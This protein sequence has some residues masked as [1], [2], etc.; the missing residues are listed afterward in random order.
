MS[1]SSPKPRK[2]LDQ[3][4]DIIRLKHYSDRTGETYVQWIKRFILFHG[5]RH[6]NSLGPVEVEAYLTYLATEQNLSASSQNQALSAI[7]FLYREVLKVDLPYSADLIRANKPKRLPVVL[8]KDEVQRVFQH[9]H[10]LHLLMAKFL[11]GTGLRVSECIQLRVK[12]IDFEY[13]QIIVHDGKGE[14]DRVTLLPTSLIEPLQKHLEGVKKIHARDLEQGNGRVGLPYALARKYPNVDREWGWQYAF[15]S[16]TLALEK[17]TGLM[18]RWH[19]S[20]STLQKAVKD[21]IRKAGINKHASCH[22]FRHCFATHL[23]E[24]GYDIRTVQELLGHSDVKTTMIYTHVL[25]RGPQGVAET[26]FRQ[27]HWINLS[28]TFS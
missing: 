5:K 2:L 19:M 3:V 16:N 22:T 9:L 23:L 7:L 14:K 28:V 26:R 21:A 1:T 15:P 8:T 18:R 13:K 25:N 17:E 10:G 11:Y 6:P 27:V 4:M 24:S 20:E 12:D